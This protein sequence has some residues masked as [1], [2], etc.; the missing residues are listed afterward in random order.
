MLFSVTSSVRECFCCLFITGL[1]ECEIQGNR[2]Q[3]HVLPSGSHTTAHLFLIFFF[4][5]GL[6]AKENVFIDQI[7]KLLLPLF[8]Q[9]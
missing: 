3:Q 7:V 8:L 5:A 9:C 2:A 6:S 4:W 1:S